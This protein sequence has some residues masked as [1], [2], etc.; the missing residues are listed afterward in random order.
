[1]S[2]GLLTGL[3]AAIAWG[4][5]DIGSALASRRLGSLAVMAGGQAISALVLLI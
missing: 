3:G 2:F 5:M 1:M 4:T